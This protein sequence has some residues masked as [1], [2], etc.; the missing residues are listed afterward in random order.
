[1]PGLEKWVFPGLEEESGKRVHAPH[2]HR[3]LLELFEASCAHAGRHRVALRMEGEREG[4]AH[5]RRAAPLRGARRQLP[6]RA[7][8]SAKGDRVLLVSE[9]RPEWAIAYFGILRAG[10]TAVPVDPQLS[11][12]EVVEPLAA[13]AGRAA[14]ALV[15]EDTADAPP[16]AAPRSPPRRCP[17][18]RGRTPRRGA[19]RAGRAP[20]PAPRVAPR[21][22]RL[23]HLHQ[24]HH[25][26]AQGRDAHAPELRVPGREALPASSTSAPDD[27]LLSVLPLHHTF[28]FTAGLLVPLSRGAEIEYLDELTADRIS[29]RA[30]ERPRH[31]R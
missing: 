7:P 15:S 29:R 6:R 9:N 27:G 26:D 2:A 19:R 28:E 23:A 24:R 25:R 10:A 21:R 1:M 4:P 13:R 17:A 12:A 3:D 5:L 16:R 8:A 18:P 20:P 11:A 22:R 14:C 31:R 30:R